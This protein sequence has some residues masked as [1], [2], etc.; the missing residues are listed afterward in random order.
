M[1]QST[2]DGTYVC[3]LNNGHEGPHHFEIWWDTSQQD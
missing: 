2:Y 1:C 3:I